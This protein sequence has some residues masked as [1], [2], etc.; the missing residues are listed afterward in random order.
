MGREDR[1][2]WVKMGD[3]EPEREKG[4]TERWGTG[5]DGEMGGWREGEENPGCGW[6]DPRSGGQM[7][8]ASEQELGKWEGEKGPA[9]HIEGQGK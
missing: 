5:R 9:G 4:M 8:G 6:G 3:L 2:R 7:N 1:S